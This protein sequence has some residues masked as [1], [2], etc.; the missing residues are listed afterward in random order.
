[1][2]AF[3]CVHSCRSN[4][5]HTASTD[6]RQQNEK[7]RT[8]NRIAKHLVKIFH[9]FISFSLLF[10]FAFSGVTPVRALIHSI[11]RSRYNKFT[12]HFFIAPWLYAVL[13]AFPSLFST[14]IFFF[15]H[16]IT[17]FAGIF[18]LVARNAF[19]ARVM[20]CG[21]RDA[22][23]N[24]KWPN[25]LVRRHRKLHSFVRSFVRWLI[26]RRSRFWF[27]FLQNFKSNRK[28]NRKNHAVFM[29]KRKE[30]EERANGVR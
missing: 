30:R 13:C 28:W 18:R 26:R 20:E 2:C 6:S 24:I 12:N 16:I 15:L 21:V 22:Y 29:F 23:N 7:E 10:R 17:Y 9:F 8:I 27:C 11:A 14:S 25:I 1:M 19:F 5:T 4:S 3:F